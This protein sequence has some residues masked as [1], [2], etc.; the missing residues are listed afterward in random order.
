MDINGNPTRIFSN[1]G[2][3]SFAPD[4]DDDK[5]SQLASKQEYELA[6]K[7][8]ECLWGKLPPQ[9]LRV[10][11][12]FES[13]VQGENIQLVEGYFVLDA[14]LDLVQDWQMI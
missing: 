5:T 11:S 3:L 4:F 8:K 6:D 2:V 1:N 9:N 13:L 12:I 7:T 10:E 14:N